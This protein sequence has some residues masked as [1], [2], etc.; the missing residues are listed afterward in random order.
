MGVQGPQAAAMLGDWG[1]DVIK[2]ELPGFGDQARWLPVQ[3]GDGRS[4]YFIA[5][6]RGKRSVTVDLRTPAGRE[7]FLRLAETADVVVTN[8]KPGTME[9]WRLGYDEVAMRNPRLVYATGSTFGQTGPDAGRE[10][11]DLSAQ[12]AGGLISTTGTDGGEPTPLGAAIADHIASQN[13]TAG[14]VAALFARERTGKGQRVDTSLLGGQIWAQASE[15]TAYLLSGNV[16]GRANRGNAMIPGLYAIFPTE[17]GWIAL[18]GVV[19]AARTTFYETIGH[20]EL[21]EQFPQLL[22][23]GPDKAELFPILDKVFKTKSTAEWCTLLDA[24]GLRFAPVRD[25]A[26]VVAD[27]AVWENGYLAKV[28]TP[29]GE[30]TIVA[31]PVRFSDTPSQPRGAPPELGQHTE[32]VLLDLGYSWEEITALKEAEAI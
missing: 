1:A 6:N 8:F 23:W 5:C 29:S 13:L 17:D 15:Y 27:P 20:P 28:Q 16:A 30:E 3:P 18:V 14:I 12:A 21:S 11:A 26:E 7:V 31:T 10:G 25:H 22:Y 24:A 9:A 19:G 32:E 2:V 4:A